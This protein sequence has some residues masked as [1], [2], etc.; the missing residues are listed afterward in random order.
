MSEYKDKVKFLEEQTLK[1]KRDYVNESLRKLT[2]DQ[3]AFFYRLYPN[4]PTDN[5]LDN[6][7]DQIERTIKK[8]EAKS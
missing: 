2:I 6:A 1:F 5:Q 3:V 4:G 8:N 7:A